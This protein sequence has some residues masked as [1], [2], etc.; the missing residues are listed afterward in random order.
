MI[1]PFLFA[2]TI[3]VCGHYI[4]GCTRDTLQSP[5]P[6]FGATCHRVAVNH[7]EVGQ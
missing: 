3:L 4:S 6:H 1:K 2:L 7:F 5:C